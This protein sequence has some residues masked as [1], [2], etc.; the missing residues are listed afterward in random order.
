MR[1]KTRGEHCALVLEDLSSVARRC[2]AKKKQ[3]LQAAR[4]IINVVCDDEDA[5]AKSH[6]F[7]VGVQRSLFFLRLPA[8]YC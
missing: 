5:G 4:A 8:S 1:A 2:A 3:L 6:A 7:G